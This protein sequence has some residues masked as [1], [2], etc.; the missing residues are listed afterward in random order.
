MNNEPVDITTPNGHKVK[1]RPFVPPRMSNETRGVFLRYA[2]MNPD[3]VKGKVTSEADTIEFK[4]GIPA[5][6]INEINDITVKRMVLQV[7]DVTGDGV[8]DHILDNLRDEDY[9][10]IVDKCNEVS[11]ATTLDD[12]KKS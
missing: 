5:E 1:I 7:D 2:K 6:I 11:K 12:Q 9:R 4:D 3:I 8:L 10:A